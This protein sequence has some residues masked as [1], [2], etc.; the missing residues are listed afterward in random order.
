MIKRQINAKLLWN[1]FSLDIL[2]VLET[3]GFIIA[4]EVICH[5]WAKIQGVRRLQFTQ[6]FEKNAQL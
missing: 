4:A 6:N 1:V 3:K 5:F 2:S